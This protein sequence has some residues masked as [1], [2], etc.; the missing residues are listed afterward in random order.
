MRGGFENRGGRHRIV[1][2]WVGWFHCGFYRGVSL[3]GRRSAI[4]KKKK[5]QNY[6]LGARGCVH[7]P[8][9]QA[10]HVRYAAYAFVKVTVRARQ[11]RETQKFTTQIKSDAA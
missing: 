10:F 2:E 1:R 8:Q 4:G 5:S 11:R 9:N 7:G 6:Y 3:L